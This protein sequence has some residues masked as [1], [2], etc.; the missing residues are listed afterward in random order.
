M[1]KAKE[2]VN[3]SITDIQCLIN[4]MVC[5]NQDMQG[6]CEEMIENIANQLGKALDLMDT[7]PGSVV[8]NFFGSTF[9]GSEIVSIGTVCEEIRKARKRRSARLIKSIRNR[10]Y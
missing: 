7:G 6:H 5:E 8:F 9:N 1:S 4:Y 10:E 3:Q 2:L